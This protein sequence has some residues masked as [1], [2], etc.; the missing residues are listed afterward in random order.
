M[1]RYRTFQLRSQ[2]LSVSSRPHALVLQYAPPHG[3]EPKGPRTYTL[4]ATPDALQIVLPLL[5]SVAEE[6]EQKPPERS[7]I[8]L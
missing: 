8:S 6:N 4:A 2:L 5:K 7:Q 3:E 1:V